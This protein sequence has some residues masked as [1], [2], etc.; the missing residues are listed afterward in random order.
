MEARL[1][2]NHLVAATIRGRWSMRGL[3]KE[4]DG[5]VTRIAQIKKTRAAVWVLTARAVNTYRSSGEEAGE[6]VLSG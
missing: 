3:I 2:G 1:V 4:E 6:T 5:E